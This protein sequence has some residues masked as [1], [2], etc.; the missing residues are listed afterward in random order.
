MT[1]MFNVS[2]MPFYEEIRVYGARLLGNVTDADDFAQEVYARFIKSGKQI[3]GLHLRNWL[4]RTARNLA[5]DIFRTRNRFPLKNDAEIE[6]IPEP[7]PNSSDPVSQIEQQE[8]IVR[9]LAC[10]KDSPEKT[11]II[12]Y[13]RFVEGQSS[14]EISPELG[15]GSS[16]VRKI[17]AD[18][19]AEIRNTLCLNEC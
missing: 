18:T 13:K 4:F 14:S 16:T 19:I 7:F 2:R 12:F 5:I 8:L 15:I 17:I 6:D 9:V 1:N 11:R 3:D 10:L